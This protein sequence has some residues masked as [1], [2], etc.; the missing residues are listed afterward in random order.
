MAPNAPV[1][2]P[3]TA[4]GESRG[5]LILGAICFVLAAFVAGGADILTTNAWCWGFGGFA[6]WMLARTVSYWGWW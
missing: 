2:Q 4:G 1:R 6:A 3:V 5:L